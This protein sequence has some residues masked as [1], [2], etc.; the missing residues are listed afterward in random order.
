MIRREGGSVDQ[1]VRAVQELRAMVEH[2]QL[3]LGNQ[4]VLNRPNLLDVLADIE[5]ALPTAVTQGAAVVAQEKDILEK[6]RREAADMVQKARQEA[7]ALVDDA[8]RKVAD[9]EASAK[10]DSEE[11]ARV[12]QETHN[13][14]E[15]EKARAQREADSIRTHAERELENA[16]AQAQS[17]VNSAKQQGDQVYQDL[18]SR[19]NA[20]A[21]A[22]IQHAEMQAQRAMTQETVYNMALVKAQEIQDQATQEYAIMRQRGYD[23]ANGI[24]VDTDVYL[25]KVMENL[26]KMQEDIRQQCQ[27]LAGMH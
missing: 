16:H 8:K 1:T 14:A 2:A 23:Y 17:I 19:A 15:G 5:D 18:I 25:G 3:R 10:R 27:A 21:N 26:R 7:Q 9:L 12:K 11:A 13:A 20:D 4:C 6:A 22:I 24:L